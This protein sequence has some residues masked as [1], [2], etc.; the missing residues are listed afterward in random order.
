[1]YINRFTE[2]CAKLIEK[3]VLKPNLSWR[4]RRNFS[5]KIGDTFGSTDVTAIT[6]TD[7]A[8]AFCCSIDTRDIFNRY[9]N[10]QITKAEAF[11]AVVAQGKEAF[12]YI[13]TS[14]AARERNIEAAMQD[15]IEKGK[16]AIIDTMSDDE[17]NRYA[18][19]HNLVLY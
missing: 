13:R 11:A 5:T 19:E 17:L 7:M 16:E 12:D 3:Q 14:V 4:E 9:K 8:N 18:E 1:M 15:L 10:K 2:I 6:I